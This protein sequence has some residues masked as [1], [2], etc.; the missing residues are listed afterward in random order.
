MYVK[1][2]TFLK[3]LFTNS[4]FWN[5]VLDF[6]FFTTIVFFLLFDSSNLYILSWIIF[7]VFTLVLLILLILNRGILIDNSFLISFLIIFIMLLSFV[8]NGARAFNFTNVFLLILFNIFYQY[9]VY[10]KSLSKIINIFFLAIITFA[11]VFFIMHVKEIFKGDFERIGGQFANVNTVGFYFTIGALISLYLGLFQK[12]YLMLFLFFVFVYLGFATGSKKVFMSVFTLSLLAITLFFG[13][14]RFPIT[15]LISF[16]FVVS[17]FVFISIPQFSYFKDRLIDFINGLFKE[18]GTDGSTINRLEM[19]KDGFKLFL[20]KPF[21]GWGFHGVVRESI[22][23]SYSHN[24]FTEILANFG[25][26]AFLL[27]QFLVLFPLFRS[28]YFIKQYQS[29][30]RKE[31]ILIILLST[32][33]FVTQFGMVIIDSKISFIILAII[34]IPCDIKTYSKQTYVF[35]L[36]KLKKKMLL[37]NF[38]SALQNSYK[39]VSFKKI[40]V[41]IDVK[42]FIELTSVL[43]YYNSI[44]QKYIYID[45]PLGSD[46]IEKNNK[47]LQNNVLIINCSCIVAYEEL[48]SIKMAIPKTVIVV[49]N[50]LKN[51][52]D[53][54]DNINCV[55][56]SIIKEFYSL[57]VSI[58]RL[59]TKLQNWKKEIISPENIDFFKSTKKCFEVKI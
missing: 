14:K 6:L 21:L 45:K 56:F 38:K 32:F 13:K 51:K 37:G 59:K 53:F 36:K 28:A 47:D 24:N 55:S 39:L 29:I 7:I 57:F 26:F 4:K 27:F 11:L 40:N 10:K 3:F 44:G 12:K 8:F 9:F 43:H 23:Q 1:F 5:F 33:V 50:A 19:Y 25:L 49:Y 20:Y 15:I 58:F 16:L 31:T 2:N 46:F 18:G 34:N 22:F 41:L 52:I 54:D 35:S 48:L 17:L 42:T 30:K